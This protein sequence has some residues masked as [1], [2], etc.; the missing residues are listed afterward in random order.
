M[1]TRN[2]LKVTAAA[3]LFAAVGSQAQENAGENIDTLD[4]TMELMPEGATLPEAVTRVIELPEGA[5]E[6]ARQN[7]AQ[8]LETANAARGNGESGLAIA[9]E[10]RER[11][12]EQAQED[13]ENAG[14]GPPD[15]IGL[16]D[17]PGPPDDLPGPPDVPGP[18]GD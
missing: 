16:P 13:R 10:A 2:L 3:A 17:S 6:A 8:G 1:H 11:G 14:R 5:A 7:A 12:M 9:A 4:L 15:W 18:P